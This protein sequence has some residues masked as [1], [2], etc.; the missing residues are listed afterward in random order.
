MVM[1]SAAMAGLEVLDTR[2]ACLLWS[3]SGSVPTIFGSKRK[4][5]S[6]QGKLGSFYKKRHRLFLPLLLGWFAKAHAWSATVLVDELDAGG[7]CRIV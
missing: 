6:R 7:A 1:S 5:Q 3:S 4:P 2:R